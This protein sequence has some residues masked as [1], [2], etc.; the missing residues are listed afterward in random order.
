MLGY[1]G[2]N[3]RFHPGLMLGLVEECDLKEYFLIKELS[4]LIS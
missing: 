3:L 2:Y 4:I 1:L